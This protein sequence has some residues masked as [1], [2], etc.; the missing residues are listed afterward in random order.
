VIVRV[1]V[2]PTVNDSEEAIGAIAAFVADLGGVERLELIP[3]HRLGEAKRAQLG[4]GPGSDLAPLGRQRLDALARC[5]ARAGVAVRGVSAAGSEAGAAERAG[6]AAATYAARIEA[7]RRTKLRHTALK[8]CEGPRDV[9]DWGQIPLGDEPFAFTPT[10][11]HPRG[12]VLGPRDCGRNFRRFLEACPT[13]VDPTS[14][15]LGGYYVTFNGFVT[16]WDPDA[17]W[18][19]LEPEI[20]K[21]GIIHGIDA[22]QHFL[23][24]VAVG[25]DLGLG[26]LLEKIERYRRINRGPDQQAYYDGLTEFVRGVQ[27]WIGRHADAARRMAASEPDPLLRANLL[28]MAAMNER[29]VSAPPATFR[30]ACQWLAWY[31][32]AKRSYIG[33]GPLGRLDQILYP[34]YQRDRAAGRLSDEDAVFDLACLLVKDSHYI[35]LGGVD[36]QGRD[37]T[38][39]LSLLFLEAA[40]RLRIPANL[41]VVVH[42][43]MD[44][45]LLDRAVR[46]LLVGRM[47]VPRFA[48]HK[49]LVEGLVRGGLPPEVARQRVQAGCHWFCLPGLEYSFNDVIKI[50]FAKVLE[51]AFEEMM[52]DRAAPPSVAGL[53]DRFERHLGRAV[54]VVAQGI[55]YHME[56]QHRFYPEL[57][58][59]LLCHGPVEKGVDASHGSLPYTNIGVDG[60]ALAT[61]ADAFAAMERRIE[62][63]GLVTWTALRGALGRSWRRAGRVRLLMQTVPGYGRGETRGQAWAERISRCFAD[64]VVAKPTPAGHRMLPGLFSWASVLQMGRQ[65]GATPDGRAAGEPLSFGANPI[66]GRLHGG[67]LAATALSTAVARVQPGWG[68]PAPL[69]LDF[70]PGSVADDEDVGRLAALFRTH[71][72]LGGT[73]INANVLDREAVLEACKDPSKYPDLMVRV[74]GFSAYFASLSDE[75]RRLI[76]ERIVAMEG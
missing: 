12:Y 71:F 41:A 13:Y 70:D 24:D 58:L 51:V 19:H 45:R 50:N 44:E 54:E 75:F 23:S 33:G 9:D 34:Y 35:Q 2:V 56:H 32:M 55:D 60:A 68:N 49:A 3:Y 21:Y 29:L 17:H 39:P 42:D 65:T 76:Y 48:G 57:A 53:W 66:P 6:A 74:T 15:L 46:L 31:Q 72:D 10:T 40:E 7:L 67:P 36:P 63:E 52:D 37:V 28:E 14:S 25:L 27:G 69:Q 73:L 62:R 5:A 61:V 22:T 30:E 8:R 11:D 1:P 20:R 43:G 4:L 16:R 18:S 38:N 47:G 64:L 26:G 59:S